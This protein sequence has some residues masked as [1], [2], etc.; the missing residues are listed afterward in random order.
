[1]R[2]KPAPLTHFF[3][4][5]SGRIP[6]SGTLYAQQVLSHFQD[7]R[8]P[9]IGRGGWWR[10]S[11]KEK[12]R[13]CLGLKL[14]TVSLTDTI[15]RF[16]LLLYPSL[17][18]GLQNVRWRAAGTPRYSRHYRPRLMAWAGMTAFNR[19]RFYEI[20]RFYKARIDY[21]DDAHWPSLKQIDPDDFSASLEQR[22]EA[23]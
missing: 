11:W 2:Q 12:A 9:I 20:D 23:E 18:V 4:P 7:L 1:M 5:G 15:S 3:R 8:R 22:L 19:N 17:R 13:L 6:T 21:P 14:S 16:Y 10:F